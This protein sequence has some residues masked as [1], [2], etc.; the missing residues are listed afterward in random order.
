MIYIPIG[1]ISAAVHVL[2][3]I[4]AKLFLEDAIWLKYPP[5]AG[6]AARVLSPAGD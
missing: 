5:R 6:S 3:R 4:L 2:A 1:S